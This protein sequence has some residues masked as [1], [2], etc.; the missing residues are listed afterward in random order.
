MRRIQSWPVR[1]G[2]SV[3]GGALAMSVATLTPPASAAPQAPRAVAVTQSGPV[4][5]TPAIGTPSLVPTST[6]NVVV[7]QLVQC[8]GTMFAVGKFTQVT[9]NGQTFTRNNAFSFSATAPYTMSTWDP[10]VNGE[11]NSIALSAD[12][13]EAYLGGQFTSVGGTSAGNIA[14]VDASTGAVNPAF[15]HKAEAVV[16][17]LLLTPST[18]PGGQHL[19]VGGNDNAINGS[20]ADP[21]YTSLDPTTGANDGYLSLNISGHYVYP[22]VLPNTTGVFNQQLSPDGTE[23][24]VEGDFTSVGGQA[25][26]QIFMLSLG[27]TSA[28][29]TGWYPADFSQ[30]CGDRHPLYVKAAAWSP[31]G[32]TVYVADTGKVILNWNKSFPL[33]PPNLCDVIAAF[34]SASTAGPDPLWT[35]YSGCDSFFSVAADSFAVYAGGH[36][37]WADNQNGCDSNGSGSIPDQGLTGVNPSTG[38]LITNAAGTKGAYSMSRANADDMLIIPPG[39]P[40]TPAPPDPGLWIASTDRFGADKCGG[41]GGHTGICFLPYPA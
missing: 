13:S 6:A 27:A 2:A 35:N 11:V 1:A 41:A 23:V 12:C 30:F 26:Q 16:Y 38:A 33:A 24:L 22:G 8:N 10:N 21:Y 32:K 4:S 40:G 29:L 31:D 7:R 3:I 25:R 17:T 20:N 36:E 15:G 14:E 28:T 39:T 19:L 18:S 9:W 5:T 34:P 37:R